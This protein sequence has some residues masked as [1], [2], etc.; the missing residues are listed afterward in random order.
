MAKGKKGGKKA[1]MTEEE[2]LL[3]EQ[4]KAA[5]EEEAKRA[6][7]EMILNFLKDKLEKE[8]KYSRL[9]N[10]KLT[11]KWRTIMRQTKSAELKREI[12]I[13]S[14]TFER[15]MDRK[16]AVIQQ[17]AKDLEESEEQNRI[18]TRA[19]QRN[20]QKLIELQNASVNDLQERFNY[21]LEEE[22]NKFN[23]DW[24]NSED[25]KGG[26]ERD[27]DTVMCAIEQTN[28]NMTN[29]IRQDFQSMRDEMKNRTQDDKH[30]LRISLETAVENLWKQFQTAQKHYNESTHERRK[31]FEKLQQKDQKSS[32]E[33]EQQMKKLAKI[34]EN[35]NALRQRMGA[36]TKEYEEKHSSLKSNKET[37]LVHFRNLKHEMNKKRESDRQILTKLTLESDAALKRCQMVEAK[38]SSILKL[39]EMCRKL[40]TEEEKVLPF[41]VVPPTPRGEEEAEEKSKDPELNEIV[42]D[43]EQ[44]DGFWRRYNKVQLDKLALDAEKRSLEKENQTL[45]NVL[46]QYL[47]GVSVNNETLKEPNPLFVV[48][49]RTNVKLGVNIMDPRI[50]KP[51]ATVV[52]AAHIVNHTLP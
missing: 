5:A 9:N 19:H 29:D 41:G 38:A 50:Q 42:S 25:K 14:Q 36:N 24:Q 43:Y 8:Q 48:N 2:R 13:L 6:E 20:L 11:E 40:E 26:G 21:Q 46:R 12:E 16:D 7:Q 37:L 33:I 22:R 32:F 23:S 51:N 44:L 27:F 47:D 35:I 30:A 34:Q 39:G 31:E 28:I 52:E 1:N 10:R 18:A 45:R 3:F 4:Q 15:I 49:Q 17:F